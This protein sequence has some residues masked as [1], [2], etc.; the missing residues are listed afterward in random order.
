MS[1]AHD[2][3]DGRDR[4]AGGG[5]GGCYGGRSRDNVELGPEV[6]QAV[7]DAWKSERVDA[8]LRA[9]VLSSVARERAEREGG[10]GPLQGR[11]ER[12]RLAV[13]I[14]AVALVAAVAV[15][16]GSNLYFTTTAYA[17]IASESQIT[18][19]VNRF[20]RVVN[21]S[22]EAGT[23]NVVGM[24]YE[25]ALEALSAEGLLGDAIVDVEVSSQDPDQQEELA[26][27]ST[28]C[29]GRAGHHGTCNGHRYGQEGSATGEDEEVGEDGE[30]GSTA[31]AA[32]DDAGDHA[33]AG[34]DG[35]QAD[36][37]RG[38]SANGGGAQH[39]HAMGA[40]SQG[41]HHASGEAHD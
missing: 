4:E 32:G 29:L 27:Q 13:A 36:T 5:P 23:T 2:G 17:R 28:A 8:D 9:R 40:G 21:A 34:G 19:G 33:P 7:R 11:P 18:L 41:R 1:E 25:E 22:Q 3:Y 10:H 39:R 30:P 15:P 16:A 20:G 12:M 31:E 6:T 14:A 26:R 38:G 37:A 35:M 24:T